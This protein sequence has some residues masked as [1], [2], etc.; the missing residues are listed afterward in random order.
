MELSCKFTSEY[1]NYYESKLK[2]R[3]NMQNRPSILILNWNTL[4]PCL[5]IIQHES[6]AKWPNLLV[7]KREFAYVS[8]SMSK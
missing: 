4:T 3:P 2:T 8:S 6:L 1:T 7:F 5:L